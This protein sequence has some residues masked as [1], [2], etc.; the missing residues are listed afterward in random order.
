MLSNIAWM[1]AAEETPRAASG[2]AKDAV[3]EILSSQRF[4]AGIGFHFGDRS[5]KQFFDLFGKSFHIIPPRAQTGFLHD[6]FHF[7]D[8]DERFS[9]FEFPPSW[10]SELVPCGV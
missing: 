1:R 9:H 4:L 5:L 6:L 10:I 7:A 3:L 2:S 8:D